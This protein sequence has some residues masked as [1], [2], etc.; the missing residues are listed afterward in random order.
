VHTADLFAVA[1]KHEPLARS[2][3]Y[4]GKARF[5]DPAWIRTNTQD[6]NRFL[7]IPWKTL[8]REGVRLLRAPEQEAA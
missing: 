5:S 4:T 3:E 7:V 8:E 2:R 6:G 1:K